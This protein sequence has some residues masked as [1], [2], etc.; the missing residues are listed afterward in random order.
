M[1]ADRYL[2]RLALPDRPGGLALVTRCLANC[3]TDILAVAVVGHREGQAIDDLLV[4]G[5][6]LGRALAALEPEVHLLGQRSAVDLPDPGTAM[7]EAFGRTIRAG[8]PS[9]ARE[10]LLASL[11]AMLGADAGVLFAAPDRQRLSP[12]AS[13][14]AGLPPI[15]PD[16]P[17]IARR[18]LRTGAAVIAPAEGSWAP[19]AYRKAIAAREVAAAPISTGPG[20]DLVLM[21][22]RTDQFPFVDAEVERASA[23]VSAAGEGLL[24][25]ATA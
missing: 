22:A 10:A 20:T 19:L 8:D 18:A 7:A 17:C 12:V 9:T 24:G 2:I 11:L 25:R 15:A 23:L 6:D 1:N 5:G 3:G 13:I 4:Q 16:E 14:P 21:L